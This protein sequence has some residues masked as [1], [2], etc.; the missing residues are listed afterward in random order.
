[1][2]RGRDPSLREG[3]GDMGMASLA[4][5]A[6]PCPERLQRLDP[7]IDSLACAASGREG[8][9]PPVAATAPAAGVNRAAVVLAA[10]GMASEV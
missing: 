1:M 2:R 5:R 10:A 9:S 3:I 7:I 8:A 4:A 6:E